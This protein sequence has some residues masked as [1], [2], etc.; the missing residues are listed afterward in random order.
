MTLGRIKNP[1]SFKP[2]SSF[3]VASVIPNPDSPDRIFAV[4]PPIDP[5][6]FYFVNRNTD[7][8]FIRNSEAGEVII[9][10]ITQDTDELDQPITLNM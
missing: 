5:T 7:D 2:T 9:D 1:L 3:Y 10:S 6:A 8:L 4:E